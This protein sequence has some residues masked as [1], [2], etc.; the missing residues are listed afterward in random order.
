MTK[1]TSGQGVI[2]LVI[3]AAMIFIAGLSLYFYELQRDPID[4]SPQPDCSI[5]PLPPEC[6][7]PPPPDQ[8]ASVFRMEAER[9]VFGIGFAGTAACVAPDPSGGLCVELRGELFSMISSISFFPAGNYDITIRFVDESDG[10]DNYQL[11]IGG[12]AK[13]DW[14]A[15][16][17]GNVW[18]TRT[19]TGIPMSELETIELTCQ[20]S[21]VHSRCRIDFLE[22]TRIDG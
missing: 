19:I 12:L 3:V 20:R 1:Q 6:S 2:I 17:G 10:V 8:G 22:F 21:T 15:N 16:Q 13:A 4:D 14:A 7:N 11:I 9:M 5:V 18:V